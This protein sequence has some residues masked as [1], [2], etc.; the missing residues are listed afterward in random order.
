MKME[1]Y[2]KSKFNYYDAT[3]IYDDGI[4]IVKAGS[5]IRL[6]F[7]EHIK[8]GTFSKKIRDKANVVDEYGILLK[9]CVFKSPSTAAQFVS[10]ASTNGW[11]AWRVDEKR[12]LRKYF[13]TISENN[14]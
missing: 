5:R 3:A 13:D 4:I 1:I 6:H 12:N 14:I 8:G 9:D 7:A 10:G 11:V 2:M